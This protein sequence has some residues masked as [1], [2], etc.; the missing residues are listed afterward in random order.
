MYEESL[1][2][3]WNVKRMKMLN[4][5]LRASLALQTCQNFKLIS[6]WGNSYSGGEL[7][8]EHKE[9]IDISPLKND[10]TEK[11]KQ[12][13]RQEFYPQIKKIAQKHSGEKFTLITRTDSDDK[14][15]P[16]FVA[17]LQNAVKFDIVP[18]YYDVDKIF[19]LNRGKFTGEK[20]EHKEP[21]NTSAF[22][23]VLEKDVQCYSYQ[24]GGHPAVGKKM[25]GK[26]VPSL[27]AW[28]CLHESN[29]S[30]RH[31]KRKKPIR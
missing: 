25:R 8:N 24:A 10:R 7:E 17:K 26:I 20:T 18:Y 29:V 28:S 30:R 4:E 31:S 1:S 14:F 21:K 5:N 23:S 6:L 9:F 13:W 16:D 2:E 11:E 15:E 3:E 27:T 22:V 19:I 12:R